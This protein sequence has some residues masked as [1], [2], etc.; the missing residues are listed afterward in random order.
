MFKWLCGLLVSKSASTPRGTLRAKAVP[1]PF[2]R[3]L[4]GLESLP[5]DWGLY[6]D[7]EV[8][9]GWNSYGGVGFAPLSDMSTIKGCLFLLVSLKFTF[10]TQSLPTDG[11]RV[12]LEHSVYRPSE[13][14]FTNT[15]CKKVISFTWG[16][17]ASGKT[18]TVNYFPVNQS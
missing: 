10:I 11:Q 15:K 9:K 3:Y 12:L 4:Y 7:A 1:A 6:C 8:G 16:R 2:L 14:I 13:I 17:Q 18:I 5:T